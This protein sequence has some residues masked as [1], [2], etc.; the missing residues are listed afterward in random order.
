MRDLT[1]SVI[2]LP[3]AMSLFGLQQ[4]S[5][6][7]SSGEEGSRT[8]ATTA[9]F[10][11]VTHAAEEQLDGWAKGAFKTGDGLQRT[12]V[13]FVFHPSVPDLDP[14]V[15]MRAMSEIQGGP[16]MTV[17][18]QYVLPSIAWLD[19][20][21]VPSRD[22]EV[23][24]REFGNKVWVIQ[25]VTQVH[26]RLGGEAAD[27]T[28]IDLTR[29]AYEVEDFPALWAVEGTGN[30]AAE[31]SWERTGEPRNLLNEPQVASLPDKSLTMLH[32][33]IGMSFANRLLR[34]IAPE[35]DD[36]QV[37]DVISRFV[38]LCT[39]SSR[40]GCTGAALES[41]GLATRTLY[42]K[43]VQTIDRNI[44]AVD[45]RLLGY[46]WH[47]AGRAIYFDPTNLLPSFAAPWRAVE[48]CRREA[49]HD[50][51]YDNLIAGLS[52][53]ITVVNMRHPAVMETF[54]RYHGKQ[55]AARGAFTHGVTSALMMRADTTPEDDNIES[56]VEH[57]PETGNPEVVDLWNRLVRAP[58]RRAL[59]DTYPTL[60]R[61]TRLEE[62][63]HYVP[64][65]A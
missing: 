37:R 60:K 10:D 25:L 8:G 40:R 26:A 32:A 54:L 49:P 30:F 35:S 12:I 58:C 42:P 3:W 6:L 46:F 36:Q 39:H 17:G 31:R 38:S 51:A 61:Q 23:A 7:V 33:G 47:G 48:R 21:L 59:D 4:M 63:F 62:L 29:R 15:L 14:S 52:W 24:L 2:G 27:A 13:D 5:N 44:P 57:D 11:A 34:T 41:L 22:S 16:L 64:Q 9:A 56:F 50:V 20:F 55:L 53:A 45:E 65:S 1:K 28:L 19:S 18:L 43:L